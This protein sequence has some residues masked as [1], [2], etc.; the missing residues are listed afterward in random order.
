MSSEDK[1]AECQACGWKG[2]D[3]D[4]VGEGDAIDVYCPV[5]GFRPKDPAWDAALWR[6]QGRTRPRTITIQAERHL[7]K[8]TLLNIA[9][10][11][12]VDAAAF[13]GQREDLLCLATTAEAAAEAIP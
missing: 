13:A 10:L 7:P 8:Q 2:R 3:R 11:A 5:C 1:T 4:L 6:V 9:K 12:R